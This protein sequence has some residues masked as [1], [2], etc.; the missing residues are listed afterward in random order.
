MDH[1]AGAL[2]PVGGRRAGAD[3]GPD[4]EEFP[5]VLGE[6][7]RYGAVDPSL[8]AL[9]LAHLSRPLLIESAVLGERIYFC[10]DEIQ[11]ETV[12]ASGLVTYTAAELEELLRVATTP[13]GLRTV[14]LNR[15]E[16]A[17]RTVGGGC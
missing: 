16:F 2:E 14:H 7:G 15:C 8:L 9:S 17:G 13:E 4:P 1:L 6:A 3:D 12:K 5:D 11:T 10:A